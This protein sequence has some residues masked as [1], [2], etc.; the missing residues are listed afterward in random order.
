[1]LLDVVTNTCLRPCIRRK[2]YYSK[3]SRIMLTLHV[4]KNIISFSSCVSLEESLLLAASISQG[5]R[6][7]CTQT[8]KRVIHRR[9]LSPWWYGSATCDRRVWSSQSQAGPS[10]CYCRSP[11][12]TRSQIQGSWHIPE[13]SP[14]HCHKSRVLGT[15]LTHHHHI[16]TK[17]GHMAHSWHTTTAL[18]KTRVAGK[19]LKHHNTRHHTTKPG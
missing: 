15:F 2:S 18:S 7:T 17:L 1:M 14:Q 9:Q 13:T 12:G 6:V 10:C 19:F 11:C 4:Y 16:I 8:Q 5:L 3:C